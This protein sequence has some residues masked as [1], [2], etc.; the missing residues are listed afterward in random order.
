MQILSFLNKFFSCIYFC[1]NGGHWSRTIKKKKRTEEQNKAKREIVRGHNYNEA[2]AKHLIS[3][4][5]WPL[6]KLNAIT[7]RRLNVES[8]NHH[9]LFAFNCK[10]LHYLYWKSAIQIKSVITAHNYY[11]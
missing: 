5:N 4:F 10:A 1:S 3:K 9:C 7:D 6:V 2:T 8:M 11:K